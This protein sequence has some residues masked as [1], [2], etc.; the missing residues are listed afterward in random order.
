MAMVLLLLVLTPDVAGATSGHTW[1]VRHQSQVA[2]LANDLGSAQSALG[3]LVSKP[4]AQKLANV[5]AACTTLKAETYAMAK[6]SVPNGAPNRDL[7]LLLVE[8]IQF[9]KDCLGV[10]NLGSQSDVG[11]FFSNIVKDENTVKRGFKNFTR[12]LS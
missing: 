6:W 2:K 12:A 5:E 11:T 4:T 1:L 9:A 7:A 8:T 3:A 10:Q